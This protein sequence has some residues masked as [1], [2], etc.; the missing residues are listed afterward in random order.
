MLVFRHCVREQFP[1]ACPKCPSTWSPVPHDST[2][3][4]K[5][6]QSKHRVVD[7]FSQVP[8]CVF[9][10][11]PEIQ[12]SQNQDIGCPRM[13]NRVHGPPQDASRLPK[14]W[15]RHP[16]NECSP[17]QS[18]VQHNNLVY[19]RTRSHVASCKIATSST[20]EGWMEMKEKP[21]EVTRKIGVEE[22]WQKAACLGKLSERKKTSK[23]SQISKRRHGV[24]TLYNCST[25]LFA[26]SQNLSTHF[27]A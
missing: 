4:W 10:V 11:P 5:G 12:K 22:V 27:F 6:N 17:F 7:W 2:I 21:R 25:F 20:E 19:L 13:Y 18:P 26:N 14:L 8:D 15:N 1:N 23:E 3:R 24:E 9:Q 16:E